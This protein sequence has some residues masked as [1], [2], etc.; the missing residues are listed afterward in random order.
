MRDNR[1]RGQLRTLTCVDCK[2]TRT[3]QVSSKRENPQRCGQCA[4]NAQKQETML[5]RKRRQS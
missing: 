5:A 4:I 1:H 2:E 3:V